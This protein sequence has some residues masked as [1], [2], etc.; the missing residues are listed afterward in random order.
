VDAKTFKVVLRSPFPDWRFLF[1]MVLPRH[2]L[3]GEVLERLWQDRIDNP[4]TGDL[5]GSG[6]FL[7]RLERGRQLT[8]VRSPRYWGSHVARLDRLV[9]RFL[10]LGDAEAAMR[11]GEVDMINPTSSTLQAHALELLRRPEPGIRVVPVL[12]SARDHVAIRIG[13]GGHPAL[14]SRLVRQALAYGIDRVAVARTIGREFLEGAMALQPLDSMVF[15]GNSTYYRPNWSGYRYRP[16][17]ARR[18]LEQAGC[19]RGQDDIYACDG[20][21]L[22]LRF[23]TP[24]GT[25]RRARTLELIQEQLKRV[26]VEV[27]PIYVLPTVFNSSVLERGDYDLAL[28]NWV[29]FAST[30]G[31]IDELGC[32]RPQN[33]SGYC[34][35]LVTE[36]LVQATRILAD[37]RRVEL[38]NRVDARIAK[39]VPVIPL[40]Q[41]KR[42]F[43]LRSGIRGVVPNGSGYFTW[44]AEEWWLADRP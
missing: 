5:I 39:A 4:K 25:A 42:L 30:A 17:H 32:Q 33:Y 18:L 21:P 9:F 26:G 37:D 16:D 41:D 23:V 22:S 8:L 3:A 19:R 43:A 24:T 44:N 34:D 27:R 15:M 6:P 10:P 11:R 40:F 28:F 2:A 31:P 12:R 35:R 1:D 36:D 20:N 38:L 7:A 29:T 13:P 14:G